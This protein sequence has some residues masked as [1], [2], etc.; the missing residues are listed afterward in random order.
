MDYVALEE[1]D[2]NSDED[3]TTDTAQQGEK[4]E[5]DSEGDDDGER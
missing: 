4:D 5:V 3:E 2:D 1:I